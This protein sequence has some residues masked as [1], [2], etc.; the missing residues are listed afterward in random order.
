MSTQPQSNLKQALANYIGSAVHGGW[1]GD[2]Q[3]WE[4]YVDPNGH[5][6]YIEVS[7]VTPDNEAFSAYVQVLQFELEED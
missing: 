2:F 5:D 7:G 3:V 4:T 1:P 6:G